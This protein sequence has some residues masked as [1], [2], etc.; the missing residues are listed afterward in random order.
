M[1]ERG[2]RSITFLSRAAG[3]SSEDEEFLRELEIQGC[4]AIAVAGSVTDPIDVKAAVEAAHIP[5]AS[6]IHLSLVLKDGPIAEVSFCDWRATLEPKVTGAWNLHRELAHTDMDFFIL[7]GSL[8]SAMG[9]R[10]QV[11]YAC[12]NA[13]LEFFWETHGRNNH[14]KLVGLVDVSEKSLLDAVGCAMTHSKPSS[15]VPLHGGPRAVFNPGLLL[16]GL[17]PGIP[18]PL[19]MEQV[20]DNRL[21]HIMA[22][23]KL[24]ELDSEAQLASPGQP[25]PIQRPDFKTPRSDVRDAVS[26]EVEE[27]LS[28]YFTFARKDMSGATRMA[29]LGL[30]SLVAIDMRNTWQKSLMSTLDPARFSVARQWP[31]SSA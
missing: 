7:C 24:R 1:V 3:K 19:W 18:L 10:H 11:S 25:R 4:C 23:T 17:E 20:K 16:L 26:E 8:S 12:A 28:N 13:F 22:Q 29:S 27:I 2:A 6:V 31:I 5:V 21:S 15:S 9:Q 14:L 30:D